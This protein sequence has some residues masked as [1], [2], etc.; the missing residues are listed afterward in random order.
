MA[1]GNIKDK[2]E[3]NELDLSMMSL[4]EVP[5]KEIVSYKGYLFTSYFFYFN[6]II[7]II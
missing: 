7:I 4:K 1:V 2:L 5:L 3:G 6:S